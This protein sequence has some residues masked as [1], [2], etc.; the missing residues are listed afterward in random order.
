MRSLSVLF[1]VGLLIIGNVNLKKMLWISFMIS[2]L[3]GIFIVMKDFYPRLI[4]HFVVVVLLLLVGA[5]T[6]NQQTPTLSV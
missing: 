4:Y 1:F 3:M 2:L 5:R 6:K